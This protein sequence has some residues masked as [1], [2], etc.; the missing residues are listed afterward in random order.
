[1]AALARK[2]PRKLLRT[3]TA[4]AIA[5]VAT[6]GAAIPAAA[7]PSVQAAVNYVALGD[8]YSSGVGAGSYGSSGACKRSTNAY[9]Q[10][11]ANAHSVSQFQFVA[12]SGARTGDV[13]NQAGALS[14]STTF[15]TVSVGGNDAGFSSVMTDCSLGSDQA[16]IDR[17]NQAKAYATG[18]LP[19]LLDN[20]Y[21]T[22]KQKAPNARI[23]V[24][25][26]PRFYQ[27]GGSCNAGLSD[28]KRSAIN[29]G[30]DTLVQVTSGRAGAAGL[31]FVDV[32]GAFTGH[33]ICSSDWWLHSLT[34][35]VEESYHPTVQGQKLGY[36]P[37]LNAVT[38]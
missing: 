4:V 14:A 26:Y 1:M 6:V 36:Y 37:G 11:W 13:L 10:L 16:C 24:L 2:T 29:S 28:T 22:M 3:I 38:G 15:A 23:V 7:K 34:W 35:P 5:L 32:R 27:I 18:T 31:T 25:G 8:S 19:G 33:G 20:V 21:A 17:V 30:A 12:C 9:P